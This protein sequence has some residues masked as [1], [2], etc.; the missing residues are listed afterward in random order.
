MGGE[1]GLLAELAPDARDLLRSSGAARRLRDGAT[2]VH[3]GDVG[4]R[5]FLILEGACK[6]VSYADDGHEVILTI[7]GPGDMVGL[8]GAVDGM[9][10]TATV[11]CMGEV[12]VLAVGI[13]DLEALVRR[14]PSSM[15]PIMRELCRG[16]RRTNKR[17]VD[18]SA[19]GANGK[20]ASVLVDLAERFGARGETGTL[21]DLPLTHQDLAN[22]IGT[23]REA[24]GKAIARFESQGLLRNE[25]RRITVVDRDR[26]EAAVV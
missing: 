18:L 8:V 9:A 25:R 4:D 14:H 7:L 19:L 17:Q 24:V 15:L 23:S 5:A 11:A 16:F 1:A 21:I 13:A 22:M 6:A 2:L 3:E 12:S 26:L 10:R 20:V